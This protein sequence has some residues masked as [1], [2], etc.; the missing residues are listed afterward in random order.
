MYSLEQTYE[1]E[2]EHDQNKGFHLPCTDA[3]GK[4]LEKLDGTTVAS[5]VVDGST[6]L[7]QSPSVSIVSATSSYKDSNCSKTSSVGDLILA[8]TELQD[9]SGTIAT[10]PPNFLDENET[11]LTENPSG[12][13]SNLRD[14]RKMEISSGSVCLSFE[15]HQDKTGQRQAFQSPHVSSLSRDL[16]TKLMQ[17]NARL[18]KA[19]KDVLSCKGTSVEQY[20]VSR[21]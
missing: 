11:L 18:K 17:Q 5:D 13:V 9:Y 1:V 14:E 15:S 20:L 8:D 16:L 3:T 7:A 12:Q 10:N 19:L 6:V 2:D 21:G 4:S